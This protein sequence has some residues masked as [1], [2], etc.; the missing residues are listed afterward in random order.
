MNLVLQVGSII[1]FVAIWAIM[2]FNYK[3]ICKYDKK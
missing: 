2:T 1:A 3:S